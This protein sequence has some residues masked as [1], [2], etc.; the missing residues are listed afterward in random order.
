M[1]EETL[2]YVRGTLCTRVEL[3]LNLATPGWP[4]RLVLPLDGLY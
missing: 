2:S 1:I 3:I 4:T